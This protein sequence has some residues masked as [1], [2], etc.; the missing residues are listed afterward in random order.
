MAHS[1]LGSPDGDSSSGE[2]QDEKPSLMDTSSLFPS[3]HAVAH[4]HG[5]LTPGSKISPT[6]THPLF[7]QHGMVRKNTKY[8]HAN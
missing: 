3:L 4:S 7:A 1:G 5:G 6:S 2:S 8:F